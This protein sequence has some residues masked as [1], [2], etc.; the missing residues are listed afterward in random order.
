MTVAT[1]TRPTATTR[2]AQRMRAAASAVR[3]ARPA[4]A[5]AATSAATATTTVGPNATESRPIA[6]KLSGKPAIVLPEVISR[7]IPWKISSPPS[8]TMNDGTPS[9][10]TIAPWIRPMS[11]PAA[12]VSATV[13]QT[14]T[15]C[16]FIIQAARIPQRPTAEPIDRSIWRPMMTSA[17]PAATIAVTAAWRRSSGTLREEMNRP[18]LAISKTTA[19]ATR[20]SRSAY[21]WASARNADAR[22]ESATRVLMRRAPRARWRAPRGDARRARPRRRCPPAAP[23]RA[24]RRGRRRRG[25]RP[26]RRRRRRRPGPRLPAGA[27]A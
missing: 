20:M 3:Q 11:R 13:A 2:L 25:R 7:P 1:R 10:A 23:G 21:C 14:G 19:T 27:A 9:P 26:A 4:S 17:T 6:A 5:A 8:V 24:R 18:S 15:P 12:S 22:A 16:S